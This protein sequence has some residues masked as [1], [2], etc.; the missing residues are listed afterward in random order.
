MSRWVA[1]NS[2]PVFKIDPV[3]DKANL[4]RFYFPSF[5]PNDL[6]F[7]YC[8]EFLTLYELPSFDDIVIGDSL[9]QQSPIRMRSLD[10]I[11]HPPSFEQ[12]REYVEKTDMCHTFRFDSYRL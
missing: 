2:I 3:L 10:R 8:V 7:V 1:L 12:K 4:M 9:P 11:P 5:E 6:E